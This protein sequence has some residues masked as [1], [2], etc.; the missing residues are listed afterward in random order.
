MRLQEL[1]EEINPQNETHGIAIKYMNTHNTT[2][3]V[4]DT[5]SQPSFFQG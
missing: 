5:S 4:S 2:T 3:C 1:F